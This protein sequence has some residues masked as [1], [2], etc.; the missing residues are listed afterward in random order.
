MSL[1]VNGVKQ[2]QVWLDSTV[3]WSTWATQTETV[4]LAE[5]AN[6]IAYAYDADDVG[7]VN[8]DSLTVTPSERITLFDGGDLD[9]WEKVSGG[10]ATW[11]VQDGSM[12]SL[13]GDIRTKEKFDDFRMH[14]EWYQPE[15]AD[16]VTGQARGNSGVYIQERYEVQVLE[17]FGIDP[18]AT[19]DAASIYLKKAPDVN[20]ATPMGTWQTYDIAFRAARFAPDGTKT[21]DARLSLWWNGQLVHDDVAI[22]GKTGNGRDEGPAP[23]HIRLQDHGDPGLNPRFRNVWIERLAGQETTRQGLTSGVSARLAPST[24]EVGGEAVSLVKVSGTKG[25]PAPTGTV[26]VTVGDTSVKAVL[27]RGPTRLPLPT[28]ALEAG[29]HPVSVEY[30]GDTVYRRSTTTVDLTVR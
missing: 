28:S 25:H 17:S 24:T 11:P 23:G 9:A 22:D 2:K 6:T 21:E 15:H 4:E 19:N 3:T 16:D 1:Y 7:H 13:G 26:R 5:G 12:E 14:A 10:P 27:G 29:V 8:L 20:A 18:P 30:L